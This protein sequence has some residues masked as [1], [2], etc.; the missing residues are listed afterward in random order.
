MK[1]EPHVSLMFKNY[2]NGH[3]ETGATS[4]TALNPSDLDE[5]VGEY[6]RA[7]AR[8]TDS[9]V[10]AAAAAFRE[11]AR[12]PAARR[13]EWLDAIGSEL[14]TRK[15]ELGRLLAREVGKPLSDAVA[16]VGRAGTWFRFFAVEA[17]EGAT[18]RA[19]IGVTGI[20]VSHE[21]EPIGVV[22]VI[23]PWS[24]PFELPA[25]HIAA[26]L[27]YGNSVVFKP[28][29]SASV[30]AW[31]LSEIISRSGVPAGVF[32]LVMGS[33]RQVGARLVD[34]P[35]VA[36]VCFGGSTEVGAQVARLCAERQRRWQIDTVGRN[37]VVVL[38]D[39]K[40]DLA[41]RASVDSAYSCAGQR[42]DAASVILVERSVHERF[43]AALGKRVQRLK[44][45]HALKPGIDCGPLANAR[46]LERF[47]ATRTAA[48]ADGAEVIASAAPVQRATRGYYVE[49]LLL[50]A[51]NERANTP[52]GWFGPVAQVSIAEDSEHALRLANRECAAASTA[53]FTGALDSA[54]RF[55]RD[56]A[57]R[58]V[59]INL[60]THAPHSQA[61]GGGE[62]RARSAA[63]RTLL[64]R[65]RSI[66]LAP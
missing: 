55:R 10:A 60:S 11:S 6:A 53:V 14:V 57:S 37:L 52:R 30:C 43:V 16:E 31:H 63:V 39:A 58:R 20:D 61:A 4:G 13:A 54:M 17:I 23:T 9:A 28:A 12:I 56:S 49:P 34:H 19:G 25:M 40:L 36:A 59:L 7:D 24:A 47:H 44:T 26:A 15:I 46:Q 8:Q 64:T 51:G 29:E 27:A 45:D 18:L 21:H 41:V 32:N 2:V 62:G 5:T 48:L 50:A 3:W 38:A 65:V 22:S 35:D 66:Y 1:R 33:G 42:G